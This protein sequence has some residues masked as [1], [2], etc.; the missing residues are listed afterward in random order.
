M[1]EQHEESCI[2]GM[3]CPK[4]GHTSHFNIGA[5]TIAVVGPSGVTDIKD[6]EWTDESDCYCPQC[7]H[8]DTVAAFHKKNEAAV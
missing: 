5:E 4:C 6:V 7:D 3:A 2:E 8:S 1:S